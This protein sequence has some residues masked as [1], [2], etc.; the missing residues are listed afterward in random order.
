MEDNAH[1]AL[2]GAADIRRLAATVGVRPTKKLGQNFV[3]DPGTVR[4]IVRE[5]GVRGDDQVLEVGPGLG[6]LT[7]ALLETGARVTAV[8]IDPT[9]A[10]RIPVTVS[11]RMPDASGR[12]AVVN[13]DALAFTAADLDGAA[14]AIDPSRPFL[15]VANLPYN[16]ATPIVLTLLERFPAMR[17]FL[18]MVQDEVADRL[19]AEPGSKTYGSP[20]VK[21]AWYGGAQKA[22][23]VGRNVFWPA[24][25]VDSALVRFVR[26][27]RRDSALRERT[28]ALVDAAFAQ[29][30]KT[31]RA[32]LKGI[33]DVSVI[34]AAGIDPTLRGERLR[35]DDFAR[36][37][38]AAAADGGVA[39]D[40]DA[41]HRFDD[42]GSKASHGDADE[43]NPQSTKRNE[44][45]QQSDNQSND[46]SS[47]QEVRA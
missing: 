9:L 24:P 12:F 39:D 1:D 31:L 32:A 23:K 11:E 10:T 40:G 21:L 42:G 25:N 2:L 33:V 26:D 3:I 37:A 8:E 4:R 35:I 28:F 27:G 44:S 20:S 19:A 41:A 14:G 17:G 16:V 30:R 34:E 7:L 36:L 43:I 29:R 47:T 46:E 38:A 5:A 13:R 18:V 6:S 22:G 45:F 15:L